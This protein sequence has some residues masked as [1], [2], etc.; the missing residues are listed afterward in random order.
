[1]DETTPKTDAGTQEAAP[2]Y[3]EENILRREVEDELMS[4]YK[5][6]EHACRFNTRMKVR[7]TREVRIA[8]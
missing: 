6:M 4:L 1:M 3:T 7:S 2:Q 5:D 8:V